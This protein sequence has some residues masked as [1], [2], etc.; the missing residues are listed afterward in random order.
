MSHPTWA[1]WFLHAEVNPAPEAWLRGPLRDIPAALQPPAY[2]LIQSSEEVHRMLQGFPEQYL[3]NSPFGV[4]SV[5][6]HLQHMRGVQIRMLRYA[7]GQPL[8]AEEL[9]AQQ[10]EGSPPDPK[11]T[12]NELIHDLDEQIQRTL[13]TFA[14]IHPERLYEPRTVG[15]LGY[16]STV[17]G[18][19]VHA[20]EH[21]QRHCGQLYVTV[22]SFATQP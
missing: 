11:P 16:P 9:L 7:S 8:S 6:F 2:A 21:C 19:Y 22:R 1:S 15:R 18:L 5:G 3:W 17:I 4:A 13:E 12:M 10:L 20:G 14:R